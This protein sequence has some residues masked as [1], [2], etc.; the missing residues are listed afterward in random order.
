VSGTMHQTIKTNE[1]DPAPILVT[2]VFYPDS[3]SIQALR[4]CSTH[5]A[6][7][8]RVKGGSTCMYIDKAELLFQMQ[9]EL[10]AW[11]LQHPELGITTPEEV[12]A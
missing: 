3:V 6:M 11:A 9:A 10:T 1:Y 8:F 4:G 12:E 7:T 2:D 5:V